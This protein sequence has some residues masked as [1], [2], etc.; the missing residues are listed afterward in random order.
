MIKRSE[1]TVEGGCVLWGARVVVPEKF[2]RKLLNELH[3]NHPGVCKMKGIARS[4]L[5]WPGLDKAI[6]Q[7]AKSCVECQSVKSSPA[8][9]PLQPWVWPQR[10]FQRVH[11]DFAG[12][13]QGTNFLVV[14]DAFSKWPEVYTMQ[15][16][17]VTK[18]IEVLRHVLICYVW[19]P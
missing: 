3:S 7:L 19:S 14:V 2:R 13:F 17:T 16:T 5:W 4:Y 12:P 8:T 1:L 11:I 18:T 9:A 10:V 6:E 15:S